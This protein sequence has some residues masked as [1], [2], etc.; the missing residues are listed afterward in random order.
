MVKNI[1]YDLGNVLIKFQP[2][3][4]LEKYV[5]IEDRERIFKMI[6]ESQYWLDL[7]R[8]ILSYEDAIEIFSKKEPKYKKIITKLFV[9]NIE[10]CLEPIKENIKILEKHRAEG[11]NLYILSNF[12]KAAFENIYTKWNFFRNFHGKVV[13]YECNLLKPEKEIYFYILKK[14]NLNPKETLFIDDKE[15]NIFA[16]SQLGFQ[17]IHLKC[18]TK[19]EKKLL[20]FF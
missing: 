7:D 16:A 14:F 4:F 11:Y 10:E 5:A 17:V 13:S 12:H 15:S 2:D 19:L 3:K 9:D 1:I 8:G 6:F 20:D 18:Y